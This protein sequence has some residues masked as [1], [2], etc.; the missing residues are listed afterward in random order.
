MINNIVII[1]STSG[2]I[3]EML[4]EK[5][6]EFDFRVMIA[7][8]DLK[9]IERIKTSYPRY[10]FLEQCFHEKDTDEF[11]HEIMKSYKN[12]HVVIWTVSKITPIIAA[13]F[14]HAGA[15]SFIS[16]RD[17]LL[18]F[19]KIINIIAGGRQY[20]SDEIDAVLNSDRAMPIFNVTLSKKEI[21]IIKLFNKKDKESANILNMTIYAFSYHKMNIFRKCGRNSKADILS[22]AINN[23]LIN[24]KDLE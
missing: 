10:V 24:S 5:L 7:N 1:A 23:G 17:N 19:E 2:F 14:I 11:L 20:Y 8:D 13:R 3:A 15:E 21:Q 12:L 4:K 18:D 6:K 16:L 9:L 22:Y